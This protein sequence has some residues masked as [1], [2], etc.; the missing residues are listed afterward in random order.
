[1]KMMNLSVAAIAGLTGLFLLCELRYGLVPVLGFL[2][3][4]RRTPPM[5]ASDAWPRVAV[6]L[7]VFREQLVLPDLINAVLAMDYPR[8]RLSIQVLDDS[9]GEA[10]DLTKGVVDGYAACGVEVSY[11]NRN[12]RAGF[13]AGALNY[14][15]SKVTSEFIV[16]FDADCKPH[17]N[18]LL[19]TVPYMKEASVAAVQARWGFSNAKHSPL[20][21][22]Q[23]GIFEWLFCFEIPVRAKLGLPAFYMGSAAVWRKAAIEA[24]GGWQ[25]EPFTAEDLDLSARIGGRGWRVLYQP[26]VLGDTI[27]VEDV[28][29]FR[30]QQ[31]R[32]ARAMM[33]VARDNWGGSAKVRWGVLPRTLDLTLGLTH[34]VGLVLLLAALS[35][36]IAVAS[37]IERNNAWVIT[38]VALTLGV[39]A[40]PLTTIFPLV[41]RSFYADWRE[42][43]LLLARALPDAM[44]MTTS[45]IF[46]ALDFLRS[47]TAEF[48]VTPKGG[49]VGVVKGGKKKWLSAHFWPLAFEAVLGT[50]LTL[51][52]V[53]ALFYY[54][55]SFLPLSLLGGGMLLSFLRTWRAVR[56][57]AARLRAGSES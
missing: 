9:T 36:A 20:T 3:R 27:A 23:A 53:I 8:D 41:Q 22:L 43:S 40:S 6:Q 38:Q 46:G 34:G 47:A 30:A 1:M 2:L 28:L 10:A 37:G 15:M 18:F 51:A 56:R 57:H 24:E 52:S 26:E 29:A 4:N 45:Q 16:Y 32:W 12:S 48:V 11:L 21:Q 39:L 7:A 44:A 25:E 35:S 33:Q 19:R 5:P 49:Q 17:P 14:G 55:E 54:P 42:R 50:A 31:R 13:K